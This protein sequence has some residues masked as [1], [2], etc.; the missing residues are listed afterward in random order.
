M[1]QLW[2]AG[3]SAAM[4]SLH[5]FVKAKGEQIEAKQ[6]PH[7]SGKEESQMA[8]DGM[9]VL[10]NGYSDGRSRVDQ[11]NTSRMS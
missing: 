4:S 10:I 2:P 7:K 6:D 5:K 9:Q 1:T 8:D 3:H 11:P